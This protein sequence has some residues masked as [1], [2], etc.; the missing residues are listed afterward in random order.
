MDDGLDA[1]W[2]PIELGPL[3]L[4]NRVMV[5]PAT[6]LYAE[7]NVLSDRHIAY[8]RERAAGGAGVIVSE[9]HAAHPTAL[10]AFRHACTAWE[11][12]AVA[13]FTRLAEALHAQEGRGLIQLYA[14]GLADSSTLN[15]DDWEPVW[16]P[17]ALVTPD[18][19]ER[20]VAMGQ[21]EI[22][23]MV[24]G[25]VRSAGNVAAASLDG[26][27]L[28][29]AHGWLV[30]QFLSPLFNHRTDAYGGSTEARCRLALEIAQA[31][32][33]A[34]P[35]LVLGLQLSADEHVG[36]A[37]ITPEE[38]DRQVAVLA[39]SG[40]FDYL[41][42]ST[43]SQFSR[44]R[45]IPPI[46]TPDAVL[47]DHGRRARR[48]AAGRTAIA[49]LG[50]IRHA[51]TG[52]RLLADGAAD[53]VAMTRAHLAD[54]ALARRAR[55]GR[56]ETT[57]PCVGENECLSRAFAGQQV[58]CVMNPMTG[59]ERAL[60]LPRPAATSARRV[61]VVGAGPAGLRAAAVAGERG[62][63]VV[64]LEA[65]G[66]PGG[67]LALTARLPGRADWA[68]GVAFLA[69]EA[70]R[71]AE[72]LLSSPATAD[73][74]AAHAPDVVVL[75]TGA[76]WEA[77]GEDPALPGAPAIPG[78]QAA[79]AL[80]V[81]TAVR[82]VLEDPGALGRHVVVVDESGE[83]L[84]VALAEL[85]G[86]GGARVDVVTRKPQVGARLHATLQ[87]PDVLARLAALDVHLHPGH[88]VERIGDGAVVLREAW[89][90]RSR[91]LE[92]ASSV[93][94]ALRRT[95]RDELAATLRDAGLTAHVIGDARSPRRAAEAIHDGE[96]IGR[97]L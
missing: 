38:T 63:S 88:G 58:A 45:T 4:R 8:Y 48:I 52:A 84:P 46:G 78:A 42:I 61:L 90:G 13:P 80:D 18:R 85:A 28:H 60:P 66:E 25:F 34:H 96:Q 70:A 36:E 54:P 67:H 79:H 14:P 82:R 44:H 83:V 27:E 21:A 49:L 43:G 92:G 10:G 37:G 22:D 11:D 40:L 74:I 39:A 16:A 17:S 55:E 20:S 29:G 59:R 12:R 3:T 71:H 23:S 89:S 53:I 31:V 72:V 65:A 33:D 9:E 69:R 75:A 57:T 2:E 41:S 93:V 15:L 64:L 97:R 86:A 56:A 50:R 81:E 68:E 95:P 94:L 7:D 76:A 87:A 19:G 77:S 5:G 32:R 47:A 24:A 26:V 1:L 62:H 30:G 73:A 35:G 91:V 6:M 51:A